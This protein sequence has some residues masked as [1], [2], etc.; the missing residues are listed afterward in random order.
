MYCSFQEGE[1]MNYGSI[2]S[3]QRK[4][5]MGVAAL[6][7]VCLHSYWNPNF[8]PWNL[9][10]NTYGNT[11]VDLFVF[12]SG[13]GIAF[14]LE[15]SSDFRRF[16]TRRLERILPA[17]YVAMLLK[18]IICV[19]T[20]TFTLK[21]LIASFIPLGV[22]INATPQFWYVSAILGYYL[23]APLLYHLFKSS[24]CPRIT[25]IL[26]V[27]VSGVLV[28]IVSDIEPKAVMR[29]PALIMGIAAGVFQ[30]L[31]TEK[32]DR[33]LDLVLFAGL[34]IVGILIFMNSPLFKLPVL[35]TINLGNKTRLW[36]VLTAPFAA[37][38]IAMFFELT[39]RSPLRFINKIFSE[40]GKYSYE[41]YIAHL[42]IL[43]FVNDLLGLS[44]LEWLIIMLL[45]SYPAALLLSRAASALLAG[46]K[47]LPLFKPSQTE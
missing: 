45:F 14:S 13:F 18:L 9:L 31:H 10:I 28:P 23:I 44:N 32:K 22:W 17:Y 20:G 21:W 34:F 19:I 42:I 12:L 4:P 16:Y 47:K 37:I 41:I 33:R 36:K 43:Y 35:N 46:F 38:F 6:M 30:T 25:M 39:E 1:L 27:I 11:G 24:R 40:L 3:K 29:I 26:L 5:I 7:I 8:L 15:K 2:L